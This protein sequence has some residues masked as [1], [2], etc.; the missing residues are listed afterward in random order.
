VSLYGRQWGV[1]K[2]GAQAEYKGFDMEADPERRGDS[3]VFNGALRSRDLKL[4]LD[5][6]SLVGELWITMRADLDK[7]RCVRI[8]FMSDYLLVDQSDG[9]TNRRAAALPW[10]PPADGRISALVSLK[11]N[12]VELSLPGQPTRTVELAPMR[13][14]KDKLYGLLTFTVHGKIRG[15]GQAKGVRVVA[16]PLPS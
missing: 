10:T 9:K 2:P 12:R 4:E 7:G 6:E 14:P 3:I 16:T 13:E 5:I 15:Q 1:F 11:G 8:G